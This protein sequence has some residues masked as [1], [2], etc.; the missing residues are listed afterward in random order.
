MRVLVDDVRL[1]CARIFI[2]VAASMVVVTG[3][4][5]AFRALLV[6]LATSMAAVSVTSEKKQL[7]GGRRS[8]ASVIL[9]LPF[10]LLVCGTAEGAWGTPYWPVAVPFV[11][12]AAMV[13]IS[14]QVPCDTGC[15]ILRALYIVM[16]AS[17]A[18]V[19]AW[20]PSSLPLAADACRPTFVANTLGECV[21]MPGFEESSLFGV[22]INTSCGA[23]RDCCGNPLYADAYRFMSRN[24][25]LCNGPN[26]VF[27][28]V[29]SGCNCSAGF[30]GDLC[31]DIDGP[32]AAQ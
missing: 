24:G 4:L 18:V 7:A 22:C 10:V 6:V 17:L 30:S 11:Y 28:R 16:V 14:P 21:C 13:A 29:Y 23:A 20:S 26:G 12:L 8:V 2:T 19:F 31:G 15:V 25:C 3:E 9:T 27:S 5:P 1:L 32:D